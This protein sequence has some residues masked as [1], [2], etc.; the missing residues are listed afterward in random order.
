MNSLDVP[1]IPGSPVSQSLQKIHSLLH[2]SLASRSLPNRAH[3]G[4]RLSFKAFGEGIFG[5][6][7]VVAA[8]LLLCNGAHAADPKPRRSP[9]LISTPVPAKAHGNPTITPWIG[10]AGV[11]ETVANIMARERK[12]AVREPRPADLMPLRLRD[13]HLPQNPDSPTATSPVSQRTPGV[14]Q[15]VAPAPQI[16]GSSFTGATLADSF[17]PPDT[18]GAVGPN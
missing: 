14:Q 6:L 7:T 15:I 11:H 2:R 17:F 12:A 10:Q 18:M 16:V 9:A 13:R 5:W 8:C 1:R 3:A 4:S